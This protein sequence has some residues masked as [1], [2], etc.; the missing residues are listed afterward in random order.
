MD[1][2]RALPKAKAQAK[3]KAK[4]KTLRPRVGR[5]S[6]E[7]DFPFVEKNSHPDFQEAWEI[8]KLEACLEKGDK[9]RWHIMKSTM[10]MLGWKVYQRNEPLMCEWV[11][12]KHTR[13]MRSLKPLPEKKEKV[14]LNYVASPSEPVILLAA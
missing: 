4:P 2:R 9:A 10:S 3:P 14:R 12:T 7:K 6:I 1:V 13:Y 11:R 5:Y 8:A